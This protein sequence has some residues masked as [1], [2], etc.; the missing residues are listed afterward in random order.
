MESHSDTTHVPRTQ[1]MYTSV[2]VYSK[3]RYLFFVMKGT[4]TICGDDVASDV[5]EVVGHDP[6]LRPSVSR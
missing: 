4:L 3:L 1:F 5:D 2:N 6:G